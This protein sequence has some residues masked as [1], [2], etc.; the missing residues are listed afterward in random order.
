MP[1]SAQG[2]HLVPKPFD[3]VSHSNKTMTCPWNIGFHL[4]HH[5][6]VP[7]PKSTTCIRTFL[8]MKWEVTMQSVEVDFLFWNPTERYDSRREAVNRCRRMRSETQRTF[9]VRIGHVH[10]HGLSH[11]VEVV[12]QCNDVCTETLRK[13]ID[14]LASENAAVRTRHS[15]CIVVLLDDHGQTLNNLIHFNKGE[16]GVGHDMV[17]NAESFAQRRSTI[18]GRRPI[19]LNPF[20]NRSGNDGHVSSFPNEVHQ[21][22]EQDG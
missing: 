15:W 2:H 20:I 8:V 14:A 4:R 16:F 21:S 10:Q 7:P 6:P 3:L 18:N 1:F 11:V 22:V 19:P 12:S 13:V 17:L 5:F 9:N